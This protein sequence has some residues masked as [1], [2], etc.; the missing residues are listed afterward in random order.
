MKKLPK[1][2]SQLDPHVIRTENL[3]SIPI[4]AEE[5]GMDIEIPLRLSGLKHKHLKTSGLVAFHRFARFYELMAEHN[6]CPDFGLMVGR[7]MPIDIL[8][9]PG[10]LLKL[11]KK[12]SGGNHPGQIGIS[13]LFSQAVKLATGSA[14][15]LLPS[16]PRGH[17]SSEVPSFTV[18][19]R[20]Y[21]PFLQAAPVPC[22]ARTGSLIAFPSAIAAPGTKSAYEGLFSMY[23]SHFDRDANSIEFDK[24]LLFKPI[25]NRR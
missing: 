18:L 3:H 22:W 17:C 11:S 16:D 19:C 5:L 25:K 12:H 2:A 10:Y 20:R 15:W 23:P 7:S 13:P 14:G 9:T 21:H 4:V 24:E 6:A 1:S 8:G